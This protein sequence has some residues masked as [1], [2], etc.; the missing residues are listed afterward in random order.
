MTAGE[1]LAEYVQYVVVG[2][3]YIVAWEIFKTVALAMTPCGWI[4]V[5]N[6]LFVVTEVLMLLNAVVQMVSLVQ[7]YLA[8]GDIYYLQELLVQVMAC[9]TLGIASKLLG[10]K[11]AQLKEKITN[12]IDEAGLSGKCFIAGTLIVTT[13]GL[14]PIEK[15]VPGDTVYSFNPET[16]VVSEQ[17]VEETFV[18][19]SNELVHIQVGNE[20]ISATPDHPFYVPQKG[21]VDAIE[22]RA[23]DALYT[24]NGKYVIVEQ[25]QHEIL[26]LPVKV[27]NFRVANNHTYFVGNTEVGVHNADYVSWSRN[28][29]N[30]EELNP[31]DFKTLKNNGSI[32]VNK[33]GSNRPLTSEPNSYYSTPNGEHIFVYDGRGDLIYDISPKRVKSF[34]INTNPNTGE[35][36]YQPYK[37]VGEVP[38][39]I[40]QL[41][42]WN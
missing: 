41:F 5:I 6:M 42:G 31:N 14:V 29:K 38:S 39:F 23:G 21:F 37:L 11:L 26:E 30:V 1:M 16:Q 7:M 2:A 10:N 40:L 20:T 25:I 22:L 4:S 17:L 24:V 13:L 8:T 32:N 3:V 28:L 34:K 19:E 33:S 35:Q 36:F 12:A 9:V 15:I 27:Y 18:R